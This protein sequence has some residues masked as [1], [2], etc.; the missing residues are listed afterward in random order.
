MQ[1]NGDPWNWDVERVCHKIFQATGDHGATESMRA[2]RVSGDSLLTIIDRENL[3]NE[4]GIVPLGIRGTILRYIDMW[5]QSSQKYKDY[6]ARKDQ[7]Q[8]REKLKSLVHEH[9]LQ[10]QFHQLIGSGQGDFIRE[11]DL[12]DLDLAL[13]PQE[14]GVRAWDHRKNGPCLLMAQEETSVQRRS[15]SPLPDLG[16]IGLEEPVEMNVER[17]LLNPN[18]NS[19]FVLFT[20]LGAAPTLFPHIQSDNQNGASSPDVPSGQQDMGQLDALQNTAALMDIDEPSLATPSG[21]PIHRHQ[22]CQQ[23]DEPLSTI[24]RRPSETSRRKNRGGYLGSQALLVDDLFYGGRNFDAEEDDN[25]LVL[26]FDTPVGVK[27]YVER[28]IRHFLVNP[29]M[30][31]AIKRDGLYRKAFKPY[32]AS[33]VKKH[34]TQSITVFDACGEKSKVFQAKVDDEDMTDLVWNDASRSPNKND[35]QRMTFGE[36]P[37]APAKINYNKDDKSEHCYDYLLKWLKID[38]DKTLP[39]FGDSESEGEY[40][41]ATWR[42]IEEEIG[43]GHGGISPKVLSTMLVS[44]GEPVKAERVRQPD[45]PRTGAEREG[46]EDFSGG[47]NHKD[48]SVDQ[49]EPE[50]GAGRV[51][52]GSVDLDKSPTPS[53]PNNRK[54]SYIGCSPKTREL[55]NF[56]DLTMDMS[57]DDTTRPVAKK[58]R[59]SERRQS[60]RE[61]R[62]TKFF[63]EEEDDLV[64]S[65]RSSE[66]EVSSRQRRKQAETPENLSAKASREDVHRLVKARA[67]RIALET[68]RRKEGAAP[69]LEGKVEI[70]VGKYA[71]HDYICIHPQIAEHLKPHQVRGIRFLWAELVQSNRN[72]GALLAHTMGLGKTFQVYVVLV[73]LHSLHV[74]ANPEVGLH[75]FTLPLLREHPMHPGCE[76]KYLLISVNQGP[77]LFVLRGW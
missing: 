60:N 14:R 15:L 69:E 56:I 42:E 23:P 74:S 77:L 55:L 64:F 54:T 68:S 21:A 34:Y 25:F 52:D 49:P 7:Q 57:E 59:L 73:F 35:S 30:S 20:K 51:K 67:R 19:Y 36:D 11:L 43:E 27:R 37:L 2:N 39:P 71:K 6:V 66:E 33:L 76:I 50:T 22:S 62:R 53:K 18:P 44:G 32:R 17:S 9:Q 40:D 13:D 26:P 1:A 46:E 70:N 28:Q 63:P 41:I 4:I 58:Q 61:R 8:F 38:G 47:T 24:I 48:P 75:S 45:R 65:V 16:I 12:P 5:R 31:L 10:H 3:K 72:V 29:E